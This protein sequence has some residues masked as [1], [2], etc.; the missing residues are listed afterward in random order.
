MS[1]PRESREPEGKPEK[2]GKGMKGDRKGWTSRGAFFFF[3]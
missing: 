2:G 3:S 1:I